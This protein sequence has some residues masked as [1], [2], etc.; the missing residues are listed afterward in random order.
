[1]NET[2]IE[3]IKC[4]KRMKIFG[5]FQRNANCSTCGSYFIQIYPKNDNFNLSNQFQ[6]MGNDISA[7]LPHIKIGKDGISTKNGQINRNK[8]PQSNN[9]NN[10]IIDKDVFTPKQEKLLLKI[11]N[12]GIILII[13]LVIGYAL[14]RL[15]KL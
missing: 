15:I 1:M 12:Y 11:K 2:I 5:E 8:P 10:P 9:Y 4:K 13:A 3:C 14:W 7:N 6:Q